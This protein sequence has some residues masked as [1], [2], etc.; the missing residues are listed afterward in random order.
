MKLAGA[1]VVLVVA[2]IVVVWRLRRSSDPVSRI[3]SM[4]GA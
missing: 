3:R 4:G 1:A 2:A